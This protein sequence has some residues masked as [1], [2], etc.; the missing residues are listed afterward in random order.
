MMAAWAER[1]RLLG[2][3]LTGELVCALYPCHSLGRG[4]TKDVALP[5]RLLGKRTAKELM[6]VE[7]ET[8]HRRT[9]VQAGRQL[10]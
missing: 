1:R 10:P 4:T 8:R 9:A 7:A 3:G 2:M 5:E 6:G